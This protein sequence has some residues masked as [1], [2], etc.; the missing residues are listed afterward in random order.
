MSTTRIYNM[1]TE[2]SKRKQGSP[3]KD[4]HQRCFETT[5]FDRLHREEWLFGPRQTHRL[6]SFSNTLSQQNTHF[7]MYI[8]TS[9]QQQG[10]P[11]K[12]SDPK[13][14]KTTN[15]DRFHREY[16]N[17]Y[18]GCPKKKRSPTSNCDYSQMTW[19]F[20]VTYILFW[21]LFISLSNDIPFTNF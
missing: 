11:C 8:E 19:S 2:I 9:K 16:I 15:F 1:Y 18:T 10:S 7:N 5:N 21:S 17:Q 6:N 14:F 13:C 3:C 12:N 20:E 4:S